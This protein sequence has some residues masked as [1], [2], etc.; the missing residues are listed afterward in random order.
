[1][2]RDGAVVGEE[3]PMSPADVLV[4]IAAVLVAYLGG[5]AVGYW[6]GNAQ[7]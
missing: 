3:E 6:A 5:M 2:D 1:V 7:R 4:I